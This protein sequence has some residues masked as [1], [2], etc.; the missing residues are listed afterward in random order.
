MHKL[1]SG[2]NV[3]KPILIHGQPV[4]ASPAAARTSALSKSST[5]MPSSPYSL[6]A[7]FLP[8]SVTC[9]TPSIPFKLECDWFP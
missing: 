9:H 1:D 4:L 8:G 2:A 7:R 6:Y 5:A 3:R